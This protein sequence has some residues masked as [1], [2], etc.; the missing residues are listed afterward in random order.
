MSTPSP[1]IALML[2]CV[3]LVWVALFHSTLPE[4]GSPLVDPVF[5]S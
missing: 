5:V 2:S 1:S 4:P 3:A